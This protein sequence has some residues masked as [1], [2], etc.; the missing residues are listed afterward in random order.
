M[1]NNK[2]IIIGAGRFGS[3]L[4]T[5]LSLEGEEV[6][7]VDKDENSFRRLDDSFSGCEVVGDGT[8]TAFLESVGIANARM[9]IVTTN[10]DNINLFISQVANTIYDIKYIY[11]RLSDIN[12]KVLIED[13]GINA[14]YPFELSMSEFCKIRKGE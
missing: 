14:I 6:T 4:A 7:I 5:M 3:N 8:D 2:I 11:V 13:S 10:E 12:K 9:I 1:K